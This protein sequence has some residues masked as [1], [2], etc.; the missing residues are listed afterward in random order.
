M[1]RRINKFGRKEDLTLGN[2]S[3]VIVS[4][5]GFPVS[6]GVK[7][8]ELAVYHDQKWRLGDRSYLFAELGFTTKFEKDTILS[9]QTRGYKILS[10]MTLALNIE[11]KFSDDLDVNR[12]FILGGD[13]G[14]RGYPAREFTGDK[15]LLANLESR[16]FPEIE[17]LTMA[18]GGIVF[19]DAGHVWDRG[20]SVDLAE[21]NA[22]AGVGLR[23]EATRV[24]TAPISRID[25]GWP[26]TRKGGPALTLGIEQHF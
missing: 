19:T 26:L 12:Q 24:P 1:E 10:R 8:W 17:I 7:R 18:I 6:K 16:V 25:I 21:L 5:A 11:G 9:L 13:S 4:R 22:S 14:L 2:D 3:A 15:L 20:E 23:L